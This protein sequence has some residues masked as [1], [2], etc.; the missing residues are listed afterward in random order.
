MLS[1]SVGS[2]SLQPQC[3]VGHDGTGN[4]FSHGHPHPQSAIT[5]GSG[6][7]HSPALAYPASKIPVSSHPSFA[8]A[9]NVT[10]IKSPQFILAFSGQ[11]GTVLQ[12]GVA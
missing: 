5:I 11:N 3:I 10:L 1:G 12:P 4:S 2:G 6:L 8:V 7:M 9:L